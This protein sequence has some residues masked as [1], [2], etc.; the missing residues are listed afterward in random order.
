[1]QIH[2]SA[3]IDKGA[4]IGEGTK[5]WHF[6]HVMPGARIGKNCVIGQGCFI[7]NVTIGDNVK[8]QNNVSVFDGVTIDDDCFIGPSVVF[9]NSHLPKVG[10]PMEKPDL[11]LIRKGCMIGA[12]ATIIAPCYLSGNTIIGAGSVVTSGIHNKQRMKGNPAKF[13]SV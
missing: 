4:V 7:G 12:N 10:T 9:T 6:V 1:M 8:I 2:E 11:T 3:I 5:I 13:Y